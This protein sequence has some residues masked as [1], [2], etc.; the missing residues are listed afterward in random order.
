MINDDS[1]IKI[2][3]ARGFK[4][5]WPSVVRNMKRRIE[6]MK[7]GFPGI[8]NNHLELVPFSVID[9]GDLFIY[10]KYLESETREGDEAPLMLKDTGNYL[11]EI[12]GIGCG[13]DSIRD[14]QRLNYRWK[15]TKF[16]W[17]PDNILVCRVIVRPRENGGPGYYY[18]YK[19]YRDLRE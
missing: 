11:Y 1:L 15:D 17:F 3:R 7:L 10:D 2:V 12:E 16:L 19:S 4:H 18:F 5:N 8:S 14:P 9:R 13:K 6:E